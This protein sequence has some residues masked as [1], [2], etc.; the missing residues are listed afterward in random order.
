MCNYN[1]EI[2]RNENNDDGGGS[3]DST[4]SGSIDWDDL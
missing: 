2:Y 4:S 1:C 3:G